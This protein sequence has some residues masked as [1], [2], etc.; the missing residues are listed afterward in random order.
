M[1]RLTHRERWLAIGLIILVT[2]WAL[3]VLGIRPT[4]ERIKTLDRVI[5]EKQR[6]LEELQ[7][8]S[9]Q[10]LTFRAGLDDLKR[11]AVSEENGFEL[12]PFLESISAELH[13]AEKVVTMKQEVLRLDSNYCEIIVETKLENLTLRKL[14]EFLLKIKSSGHFL[15][16][17]SLYAKKNTTN[18]NLLDT[19][20]QISTLELS[21]ATQL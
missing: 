6:E 19:V 10:Y 20:I 8:K 9:A 12:L 3:F 14:L 2:A 17:K 16:I 15:R 4:I 21:D 13:L 7:V 11:K 5:P 1:I 18:P